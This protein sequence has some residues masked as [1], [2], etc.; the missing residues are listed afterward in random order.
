MNSISP[1]TKG[2][3]FLP[4]LPHAVT[5]LLE[6]S[7]ENSASLKG[8][9]DIAA[10]D[11]G[12]TS[13]ILRLANSP[14][15]GQGGKVV[16]LPQAVVNLGLQSVRNIAISLSVY[17]SF[18][19]IAEVP[20]FSLANFWWH[21]LCTGV[22]ARNLAARIGYEH[23]DEAFIAGLLHDIGQ[24]FMLRA[25]PEACNDI[26]QEARS[27]RTLVKAE[28]AVWGRDHAQMGAD[29]LENWG[30]PP[31]VCDAV[32][33]HHYSEAEIK[34]SLVPVR[35]IYVANYLSHYLK[36]PDRPVREDIGHQLSFLLDLGP[37]VLD[38]LT[39]SIFVE[40]EQVSK[41]YGIEVSVSDEAGVQEKLTD[42]VA[43][44]NLLKD[45]VFDHAILIGSLQDMISA[46]NERELFD[47]LLKSLLVLFNFDQVLLAK[48]VGKNRLA[49]IIAVGSKQDEIARRIR[50]PCIQ[51]T[52]WN[53]ALEQKKSVHFDDFFADRS[54][55][56]I[57]KQIVNFLGGHFLVVPMVVEDEPYGVMAVAIPH[58][59][60]DSGF[61]HKDVLMLLAGHMAHALK[62][63]RYRSLFK[64][65]KSLN[66]AMLESVPVAVVLTDILGRSVH[67]NPSAGK[68]LGLKKSM[69]VTDGINIWDYLSLNE[70]LR[71]DVLRRIES[72][73]IFE[74][75][76]YKWTDPRGRPRWL[77]LKA[78]PLRVGS[79][80]KIVLSVEDVTANRLLEKER[81]EKA[82]WLEEELDR[83]TGQLKAAQQK[84]L[85][86]E[87][88]I[89]AED[90]ARRAAHEVAN[91]LGIIKNF[92]RVL[93]IEDESGK[94]V[95]VFDSI[96]REIDRIARIIQGLRDFSG[97]FDRKS[98]S[99]GGYI[100][101]VLSDLSTLMSR[102]LADKG[103]E[104]DI[105][106]DHDLPMLK[107]C[108]DGIKQVLINL[109]KNAED[110]LVNQGKI[111]IM[112]YKHP[113]YPEDVVVEVRDTGPGIPGELRDKIF[114]P[115]VTTK[116]K[117]NSG[118]GLSVCHG[119]IKAAGG[120][121]RIKDHEGPGAW[122]EI[123]IP[124]ADSIFPKD[125]MPDK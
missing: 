106:V 88:L 53:T 95:D 51:G 120:S 50:I 58:E 103:I 89:A 12:L 117:G 45:K 49:G 55:L 115:F 78:V 4:S 24:L 18:T 21:S 80:S 68:L 14:L 99:S 93:K 118:L 107:L 64:R 46:R 34:N 125:W 116:G 2:V 11:P 16:S 77:D 43:G 62:S 15:F 57:D 7:L 111:T 41:L 123:R 61:R 109:L 22:C 60:W 112:A 6:A 36:K 52:I 113:K 23:P 108:E 121:I 83:R 119:L 27:G 97:N 96:D 124:R 8:I 82:R 104:L 101:K 10:N 102:P 84:I 31:M 73:E 32:R 92:L 70:A 35:T 37:D 91:P 105:N 3:D 76:R 20:N 13:Q 28:R 39:D 29:L 98:E 38:E 26:I 100:Q 40:I 72:G 9:A 1:K 94:N 81:E 5:R 67:W 54:P 48:R 42:E 56:I 25:N 85:R 74:V 110:A 75:R 65:E 59:E 86:A 71:E 30:L 63:H 44:R 79:Q 19:D 66:A 47:I 33:Y 17:E 90:V 87:R 122:F 69:C 114:D